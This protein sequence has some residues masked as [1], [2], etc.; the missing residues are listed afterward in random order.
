MLAKGSGS[1]SIERL[2]LAFVLVASVVTSYVGT[3]LLRQRPDARPP[4]VP[5]FSE[6]SAPTNPFDSAHGTHLIVFVLVASDCGWSS[7]PELIAQVGRLRERLKAFHGSG[8]AQVSVVGVALDRDVDKGLRFL[9]EHGNGS[10]ASSFDQVIAGGS[11]LNEQVVRFVWR[12]GLVQ[13]MTPQIIV[14]E[15][16]V[17]TSSY[18][19]QSTIA[20]QSDKFIGAWVGYKD[21]L[22]WLGEGLPLGNRDASAVR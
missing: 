12:D 9:A 1:A 6:T 2:I 16:V 21:I 22:R 17:D 8:Y 18:V 13:A 5:Q 19:A 7:R 11:W 10:T 20:V 3:N 15:R 4:V 14:I